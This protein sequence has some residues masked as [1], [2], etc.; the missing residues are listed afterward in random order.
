MFNKKPKQDSIDRRLADNFSSFAKRYEMKHIVDPNGLSG[1]MGID[2]GESEPLITHYQFDRS[3]DRYWVGAAERNISPAERPKVERKILSSPAVPGLTE[4]IIDNRLVVMRTQENLKN[5]S[6]IDVQRCFQDDV[7][8][9][10]NHY[11]QT[12]DVLKKK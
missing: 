8:R 2:V 7:A 1:K 11:R 6:N 5:R 4:R 9:F 10:A 12:K 3:G